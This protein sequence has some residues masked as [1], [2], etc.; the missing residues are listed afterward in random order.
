[1]EPRY[2]IVVPAELGGVVVREGRSLTTLTVGRLSP[3]AV[4]TQKEVS[5]ERVRINK[6]SGAGPLQGWVSR[7][8]L[9]PVEASS[10]TGRTHQD[11]EIQVPS[12]VSIF[13]KAETEVDRV[14]AKSALDA[15]RAKGKDG[16]ALL[17]VVV[18]LLSMGRYQEALDAAHDAAATFS[19]E[20]VTDGWASSMLATAIARLANGDAQHALDDAFS[21]LD[22]F[23]PLGD[24][25]MQASSLSTVANARLALGEAALALAASK[26]ALALFRE[27]SDSQGETAA[28][29]TVTDALRA[30]DDAKGRCACAMDSISAQ[31]NVGDAT[32]AIH[33][34]LD[35][36]ASVA[37]SGTVEALEEGLKL[38]IESVQ[39]SRSTGT[40]PPL[41]AT[42][43]L[44]AASMRLALGTSDIALV[45]QDAQAAL[46]MSQDMADPRGE[47]DALIILSR[48]KL[49]SGFPSSAQE[50][51]ERAKQVCSDNVVRVKA[52]S[53]GAAAALA[54]GDAQSTMERVTNGLEVFDRKEVTARDEGIRCQLLRSGAQA[55]IALAGDACDGTKLSE[56]LRMANKSAAISQ[57][58][59]DQSGEADSL[60]IVASAAIRKQGE[61]QTALAAA[62][63]TRSIC[64][65]LGDRRRLGLATHTVAQCN[66]IVGHVETGLETA[67]QAVVLLREVGDA[68]GE[69]SA[70]H[71]AAHALLRLERF[72][73]GLRVAKEVLCIFKRLR[74]K[75]MQDAVEGMIAKTLE[76][77]PNRAQTHL[78]AFQPQDRG[79]RI[80][81]E[82]ITFPD[83]ANV[84]IWCPPVHQQSYLMYCLE[85]FKIVDDM[86]NEVGKTEILVVTQGV[87]ARQL[88]QELPATWMA[89][90]ASTVWALVR[91][92]R[93]ES[94]RLAI[95]TVDIPT[96]ATPT[97]IQECLLRA[98]SS[99]GPR[100]EIAFYVDRR[101]R[102]KANHPALPEGMVWG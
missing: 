24:R 95:S 32:K 100:S 29:L 23:R 90:A 79:R 15:A 93:L 17:I 78:R 61:I 98:H 6:V 56:A 76:V 96:A 52:F 57:V 101:N 58:L 51:A 48:A 33:T 10:K 4:V 41:V 53:V 55:Q 37:S 74:N 12:D 50:T 16:T 81:C 82:R 89:V 91:T 77:L 87:M 99:S 62:E 20:G 14:G 34:L 38:A 63:R 26:D 71:T 67:M 43:L 85:L 5:G 102:L 21:A 59:G 44:L 27:V 8:L 22:A 46:T 88:G 19:S 66:S 97:E 60:L 18:A 35:A 31:P 84:V 42:S 36:S 86:K 2:E 72:S 9:T 73:D 39:L 94:P 28:E 80:G 30:L 1:M 3:G 68:F 64:L 49:A 70:L 11:S 47:A 45:T 25:Q 69:A 92:V 40:H 7:R 65:L 83:I 54:I 13:V 75:E